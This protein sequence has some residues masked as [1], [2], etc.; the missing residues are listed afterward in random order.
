MSPTSSPTDASLDELG[1]GLRGALIRPTDPAYEARRRIW[2][3]MIDR[4]PAA[5]AECAGTADVMAVITFARRNG[6]PLS[7]RGGGHNVGGNAVCDGGIVAD[8]GRMNGVRVDT[9]PA[10][11]WNTP[12]LHI[13]LL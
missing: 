7:V 13:R 2:N 8:L 11:K 3:G 12:V 10:Q 6:L 9:A 5:I 4:R 1:A